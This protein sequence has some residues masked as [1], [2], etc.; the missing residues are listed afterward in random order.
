MDQ[1]ADYLGVFDR[2][3]EEEG[4]GQGTDELLNFLHFI[5][6]YIDFIF[7]DDI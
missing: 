5:R 6:F 4:L 3:G 7:I 1:W 2:T